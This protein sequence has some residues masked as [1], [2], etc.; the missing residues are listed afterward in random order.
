MIKPAIPPSFAGVCALAFAGLLLAPNA[1]AQLSVAQKE[2][3]G[4]T[5]L[6][7][8]LGGLMPTGRGISVSQ[9]EAPDGDKY[10]PD[11]AVFTD[12]TFN[13]ASGTGGVSNHAT[14]VG[15]YFY[16]SLSLAPDLGAAADGQLVRSYEANNFLNNV[17]RLGQSSSLPAAELNAIQNHSW[18][19][20]SS[21]DNVNREATRRMDF[22]IQRDNFVAVFGL[23]NGSGTTVPSLFAGAYNG[24]TVGLSNGSHSRGGSSIE[25]TLRTRPDIVVP[26]S[27]TSW[28]APTVSSAAGLLLE[29]AAATPALNKAWNS[30]VIKSLLMVGATR[31]E[32]EFTSAWTNSSTQPLDAVY[33]AGELNIDRSHQILSAGEFAASNSLLAGSTGWSAATSS[34]GTA[35]LY[36]FELGDSDR[37]YDIAGALVW[38]R[39][40]TATRTGL[41]PYSFNHTLAN[42][43]LRL[44]QVDGFNLGAQLAASVSEVD[45]VELIVYESLASGRYAWQVSSDTTGIDYG[46]SWNVEGS[47]IIPEP[48]V[49]VFCLLGSL[50]AL[51]RRR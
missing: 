38:N 13:F 25:G 44:F 34:A 40:V 27:A 11:S 5:S 8:R 36:F 22:M 21:D 9:V 24:I 48:S 20:N 42:L 29:T 47:Q 43:D 33:G 30:E 50:A 18:I 2:D 12:K 45:N 32:P 17:V 16:G 39:L 26:T 37:L 41:G 35:G 15:R 14:T 6:Q 4:F 23:N 3:I 49:A 31:D 51:R 10:R 7:S 28:A 46:F 1:A 19:G